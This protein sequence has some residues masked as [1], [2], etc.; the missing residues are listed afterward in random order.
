V[1]F[2]ENYL[3]KPVDDPYGRRVGHIVSFYSDADGN[4]TG[5]EISFGDF[6]FKEI[7]ID[8]FTFDAG[9]VILTP[10]CEFKAKQVE[11]RLERLRKRQVALE[12]LYAK[13]DIPRHAYE[14]FKKKLDEALMKAKEEA[15][16]VEAELKARQASLEDT[17]VELEKAM[18]S[19]KV[20]YM[21]GEIPDKAYKVAADQIRKHLEHSQ[22]EKESVKKHLEKINVLGSQPVDIPTTTTPAAQPPTQ[23][24]N[25]LP[26]V[27]LEE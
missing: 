3:G 18:T 16:D 5:L 17:I 21:A 8:R 20:S 9:E 27:V 10:E 23:Q 11:N 19:L 1:E 14:S 6:D 4:V 24:D 22:Q 26:V 7:P 13:K 15:K 2:I 12:D 25:A